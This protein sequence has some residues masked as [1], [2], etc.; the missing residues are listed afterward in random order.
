MGAEGD[1][2]RVWPTVKTYWEDLASDPRTVVMK[3]PDGRTYMAWVGDEPKSLEEWRTARTG[4]EL[5]HGGCGFVI[6]GLDGEFHPTHN[7]W[8]E[9]E[10]PSSKARLFKPNCKGWRAIPLSETYAYF[11]A[12]KVEEV[13]A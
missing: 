7:L 5:G 8:S 4:G 12:M 13:A 6:V 2:G 11:D 3:A 9:Q 1:T 10:V